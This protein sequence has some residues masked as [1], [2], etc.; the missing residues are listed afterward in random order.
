MEEKTILDKVIIL[1]GENVLTESDN[2]ALLPLLINRATQE[3]LHTRN[4]PDS[5]YEGQILEDMS[6]L[7]PV[8]IDLVVYDY[9]IRGAEFESAHNENGINRS[10]RKRSDIL[11]QVIPY[12][13]VIS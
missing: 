9:N 1:I 7:E 11:D 5:F 6:K 2:T 12:V 10:Y 13:T 3:V 4:Y 8:I